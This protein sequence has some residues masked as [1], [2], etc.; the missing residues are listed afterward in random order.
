VA[1]KACPKCEEHNHP[2]NLRCGCGHEFSRVGPTQRIR[3]TQGEPESDRSRHDESRETT[4]ARVEVPD[5]KRIRP[6][7]G[8][9]L[10]A[11]PPG[12]K[13]LGEAMGWEVFQWPWRDVL[14][15][16]AIM[17]LWGLFWDWMPT[18]GV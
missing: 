12:L 8:L 11:V 5:D 17:F 15:V 3:K 18:E 7:I 16:S 13:L 6:R 9:L 1:M 4:V 10:A 14:G 2:A